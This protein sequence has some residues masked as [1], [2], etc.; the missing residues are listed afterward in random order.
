M[1]TVVY[2]VWCMW[3]GVCG[4][5]WGVCGVVYVVWCVVYVLWCGV[6]GNLIQH[7]TTI[8]LLLEQ[9]IEALGGSFLKVQRRGM[10]KLLAGYGQGT[11]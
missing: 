7:S 8:M 6:C 11:V 9:V 5:V 4:V 10:G 1:T 2:V 3:C